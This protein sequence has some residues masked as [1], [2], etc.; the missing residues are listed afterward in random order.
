MKKSILP[1]YLTCHPELKVVPISSIDKSYLG[2]LS[3]SVDDYLVFKN[4]ARFRPKLINNT[5]AKMIS[6]LNGEKEY[7]ENIVIFSQA[8]K[9]DP[10]SFLEEALDLFLQL[11][12]EGVL[13]NSKLSKLKSTSEFSYKGFTLV[14]CVQ[15][16]D[17]TVVH[18]AVDKNGNFYAIKQAQENKNIKLISRMFKREISALTKLNG[19]YAPKI[20]GNGYSNG[21]PYIVTEWIEGI[22]IDK[23]AA[24]YRKNNDCQKLEDLVKN[25]FVSYRHLHSHNLVHDDI[26]PRNILVK[27]SGEVIII[28]HG[29]SDDLR[30]NKS[31][32][33]RV[34]TDFFSSPEYVEARQMSGE[35]PRASIQSDIY[36]LCALIHLLLSGRSHVTPHREKKKLWEE[37]H[38][39][40]AAK[41][42]EHK[43]FVNWPLWFPV[44]Q[45]GLARD[46]RMRPKSIEVI[47]DENSIINSNT[48]RLQDS[49]S[50]LI[51]CESK[52]RNVFINITST[53]QANASIIREYA[54]EP[55]PCSIYYGGAGIA[56]SYLKMALLKQDAELLHAADIWISY[57][58]DFSLKDQN[59]TCKE[60]NV[61]R[62][63][64]NLPSLCH[65][66]LGVKVVDACIAN[67][68][69][70]FASERNIIE[71]IV[72]IEHQDTECLDPSYGLA[73]LLTACSSLLELRRDESIS[74]SQILI[75]MGENIYTKLSD[76]I[77]N[78][79]T[80]DVEKDIRYTGMAHG[81][82]GILFAILRWCL[83]V[84]NDVPDFVYERVN[85]LKSLSL[86][87][88]KCAKI[89]RTNSCKKNDFFAG[90]CNGDAG[91]ALLFAKLFEITQDESYLEDA[92]KYI[93]GVDKNATYLASDIC[94]GLAGQ[95][96]VE[97]IL[98]RLTGDH[99][100]K[101]DAAES[102]LIASK[103]I[104]HRSVK[105]NSLFKGK[106][107][108]DLLNFYLKYPQKVRFPIFE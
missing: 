41:D 84:K 80:M 54:E 56:F 28:D 6:H 90:W 18:K 25:L 43:L 94:C 10:H 66:K 48:N 3:Y 8:K 63:V 58:Q 50:H 20:V 71:E 55:L 1:K 36:S 88:S 9:L 13:I 32:V 22:Q 76:F 47:F 100:W 81:W 98:Y 34:G 59:L 21:L 17:D 85:Q 96:F 78:C 23:I 44:L 2:G 104:I 19:I 108:V 106:V 68:R 93:R 64:H 74:E 67:A 37:I 15:S 79:P 38:K 51:E 99:R 87:D 31:K 77:T 16:I 4:G 14:E 101:K 86:V 73:S 75:D 53:R 92:S 102:Q 35:I 107:G 33:F 42:L 103:G 39:F 95:G 97:L 70:D 57:A 24:E 69:G 82:A 61:D 27:K 26:S 62:A 12:S 30:Y 11:Y 5:F 72:R 60:I 49:D 45:Q 105:R 83:S 65:G 29:F 46:P 7:L 40:D 52:I 91:I 89:F